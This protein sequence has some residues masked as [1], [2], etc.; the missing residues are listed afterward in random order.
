MAFLIYCALSVWVWN[1]ITGH[2]KVS[3]KPSDTVEISLYLHKVTEHKKLLFKSQSNNSSS[4][5]CVECKR[6]K[7]VTIEVH[8]KAPEVFYYLISESH[9]SCGSFYSP[10]LHYWGVRYH[11]CVLPPS[12]CCIKL[13]V[14]VCTGFIRICGWN[15]ERLRTW[16]QPGHTIFQLKACVWV[17]CVF[18]SMF[19]WC[20]CNQ[21]W[22]SLLLTCE[23]VPWW[24]ASFIFDPLLILKP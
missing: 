6:E 8:L 18:A 9:S 4:Y 19:L 17:K 11:L 16:T 13:N 23:L 24:S 22:K 21:T 14:S 10:M 2:C 15:P 3:L 1:M 5:Y 7:I 20:T 12:Y